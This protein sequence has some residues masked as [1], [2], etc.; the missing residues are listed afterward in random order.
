MQAPQSSKI[1]FQDYFIQLAYSHT[2]YAKHLSRQAKQAVATPEYVADAT[3]AMRQTLLPAE[4]GEAT[5]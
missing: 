1:S 2:S 4:M 3:Q 5:G